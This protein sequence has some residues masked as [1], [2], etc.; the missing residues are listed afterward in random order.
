MGDISENAEINPTEEGVERTPEQSDTLNEAQIVESVAAES[1]KDEQIID[2]NIQFKPI[3]YN[4]KIKSYDQV[5]NILNNRNCRENAQIKCPD[6]ATLLDHT[7]SVIWLIY[8]RKKN[9]NYL[10]THHI[11]WA[12]KFLEG[13]ESETQ[14]MPSNIE[15]VVKHLNKILQLIYGRIEDIATFD[16]NS[17]FSRETIDIENIDRYNIRFKYGEE[18]HQ[19]DY[20]IPVT[21]RD[22]MGGNDKVRDKFNWKNENESTKDQQ[23]KSMAPRDSLEKVIR[24]ADLAEENLSTKSQMSPT[25]ETDANTPTEGDVEPAAEIDAPPP[26]GTDTP[27]EEENTEAKEENK[28]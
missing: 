2:E 27:V 4:F 5:I 26:S 15:I 22:I 25:P 1:I 8:E 3:L 19:D 12:I 6:F 7:I 24:T 14:S 16:R 28:E 17:I 9:I 21:M 13:L 20:F 11:E 10:K 18:I 23:R